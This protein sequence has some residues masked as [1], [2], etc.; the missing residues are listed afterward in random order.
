M[1]VGGNLRSK[2]KKDL[3]NPIYNMPRWE[4]DLWFASPRRGW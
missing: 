3:E 1:K 2:R 4:L